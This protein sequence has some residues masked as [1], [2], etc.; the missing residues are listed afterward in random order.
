MWF[1]KKIFLACVIAISSFTIIFPLAAISAD[2]QEHAL[3]LEE[4]RR[5]T[6]AIGH[7]KNYYVENTSDEEIFESAIRGMLQGLDP[8]SAYLN[9]QDMTD[10]RSSTSGEFGGLGIEVTSQGG[11]IKIVAPIDDTPAQRAQLKSGD[12]IVRIDNVPVSDM[13]VRE[14]V[15]KMRGIK[16]TKITLTI[17]R[18]GEKEPLVVELVRD[19]IKVKSVKGRELMPGFAYVRV[20]VFQALSGK[21]LM[22]AVSQLKKQAQGKLQGLVLDLRNNPGGLLD[23]AIDISDAFLDSKKLGQNK[24]IVYTKGRIPSARLSANATPGD[25]LD[26]LPLVV[27]V[28]EGSASASEIVAGALQDHRRAIVMGKKS[29]GKG[30]VQTVLPLDDKTAVKLTT[31]RYYTP[32]GRA[33]QAKGIQ[34]DIIVNPLKIP[35]V[36]D[37]KAVNMLKEADLAGHLGE[38]ENEKSGNTGDDLLQVKDAQGNLLIH[39]DYQLYEALSL[40]KGLSVIHVTSAP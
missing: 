30:S 1:P 11:Y 37:K 34:P 33:I 32:Q 6:T 19:I 3:P 29:F 7:I 16:G 20:S 13:S 38:E 4:V 12:L 39:T 14:A 24:L 10:L 26:G 21:D 27:L 8:H 9:E 35:E 31:A 36:K 23:A 25:I 28:N 15:Q 17:V 5:F 22:D 40:L 18:E 2:T